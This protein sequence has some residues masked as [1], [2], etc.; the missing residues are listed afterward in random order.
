[1]EMYQGDEM[2]LLQEYVKDIASVARHL[3][4]WFL[5]AIVSGTLVVYFVS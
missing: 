4:K 3:Q 5:L 2:D 1:M